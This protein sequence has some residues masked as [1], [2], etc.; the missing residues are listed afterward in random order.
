MDSRLLSVGDS[1]LCKKFSSVRVGDKVICKKE[2]H[3]FYTEGR[4]YNILFVW[5]SCYVD[6]ED[7][8]L[9]VRRFYL[10]DNYRY[11]R[12]NDYFC[13]IRVL[14]KEKLEKLSNE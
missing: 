7:N 1:L 10:F 11:R 2:L 8:Y 6:I 3:N 12:Y 14:R 13:S 9:D 4:L 5:D